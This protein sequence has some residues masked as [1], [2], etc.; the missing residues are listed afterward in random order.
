MGERLL[1]ASLELFLLQFTD[2][3]H[4]LLGWVCSCL[5]GAHAVSMLLAVSRALFCRAVA[6]DFL[7]RVGLYV[8]LPEFLEISV[9]SSSLSKLLR[10]GSLL[11]FFQP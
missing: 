2:V 10:N 7:T 4:P 3:V 6:R 11:R 9:H 5:P 8:V 1:G